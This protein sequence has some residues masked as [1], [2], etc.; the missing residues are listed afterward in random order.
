MEDLVRLRH[1]DGEISDPM[2]RDRAAFI[3]AFTLTGK[4]PEIIE[5]VNEGVRDGRYRKCTD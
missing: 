1:A 5:Y 2:P 4:R 3:R